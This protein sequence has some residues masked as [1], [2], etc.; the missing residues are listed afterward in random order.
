MEEL[1]RAVREV[2][3]DL[4]H[5]GADSTCLPESRRRDEEVEH[6]RPAIPRGMD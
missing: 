3:D 4:V 5:L 6:P 2:D 1:G